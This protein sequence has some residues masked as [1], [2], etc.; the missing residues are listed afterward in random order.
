M[1]WIYLELVLT[2]DDVL[3]GQIICGSLLVYSIYREIPLASEMDSDTNSDD[4]L[5][6]VEVFEVYAAEASDNE[7]ENELMQTDQRLGANQSAGTQP[8]PYQFEPVRDNVEIQVN[9]SC[10]VVE[11]ATTNIP[12]PPSPPA[13]RRENKD[14]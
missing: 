4:S 2:T 3:A 12:M 8:E 10:N 9:M 11:E 5:V 6:N 13:D 7:E 14:W 1:R